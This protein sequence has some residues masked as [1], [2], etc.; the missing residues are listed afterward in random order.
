M[1]TS[2][3]A[4]MVDRQNSGALPPV[5][6]E[7]S[8][9]LDEKGLIL[10]HGSSLHLMSIVSE[11]L[12]DSDEFA[13][14]DPS[15]DWKKWTDRRPDFQ[16]YYAALIDPTRDGGDG[17]MCVL[18]AVMDGIPTPT[19]PHRPRLII[20]YVTTRV[21]ARGRGLASF[22][23]NF[24]LE[25]SRMFGA[26]SYVLALEESCVYWMGM[27]FVLETRETLKARLNVFPD[28][29]LLRLT[30]DPEDLGCD[31]DL[32]LGTDEAH[33]EESEE[34][35]EED[36][37]ETDD[38]E[39]LQRAMENSLIGDTAVAPIGGQ[40]H[41]L[42]GNDVDDSEMQA[43]LALSLNSSRNG[44]PENKEQTPPAHANV[45]E[46]DDVELQAALALSLE[47]G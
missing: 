9:F 33:E 13:R 11:C 14:V 43:S 31:D 10:S 35:E 4:P 34:E 40:E 37:A 38:D 24:V 36:D 39:D 2:D 22:L 21:A 30:C 28:T 25:A 6:T 41:T 3:D 23:V 17:V 27:A 42:V 7:T 15:A 19:P 46:E 16:L 29:H 45:Q 26:N 5:G 1:A 32:A 44:N 12:N 47:Q 18:R 20:D 8:E